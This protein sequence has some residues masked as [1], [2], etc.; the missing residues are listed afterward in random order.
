M[1]TDATQDAV[2][3]IVRWW[4]ALQPKENIH[5]GDR[6]GRAKLRRA[7]TLMDA[8][9]LPQTQELLQSVHNVDPTLRDNI[10]RIDT[11]TVLATLL[12]HVPNKNNEKKEAAFARVLGQTSDGLPPEKDKGGQRLSKLR[13]G[14]LM[15]AL[16]GEDK[17]AQIRA[18]RRAMMI[19]KT[20]PFDV[21]QFVRDIL[22]L[23]EK[24]RRDWTYQYWQTWRDAG[25][26][27]ISSPETTASLEP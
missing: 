10:P 15:Q 8:L 25:V 24:T 14:A 13:F 17:G 22:Y 5:D 7:E 23:N 21:R 1:T 11:I 16:N 2:E 26:A 19:L 18:L 6:A 4:R 3:V 12:A 9:M 20:T 27:E